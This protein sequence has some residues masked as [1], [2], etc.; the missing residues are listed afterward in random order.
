MN[1]TVC[2]RCTLSISLSRHR[3]TSITISQRD[4]WSSLHKVLTVV[5]GNYFAD[6][7][8][9]VLLLWIIT[10]TVNDLCHFAFLLSERTLNSQDVDGST[11]PVDFL[12]LRPLERCKMGECNMVDLNKTKL[13][14]CLHQ[15]NSQNLSKDPQEGY[16]T[17][18][19]Q[20][21]YAKC[22]RW[23]WICNY[24]FIDKMGQSC[25]FPARFIILHTGSLL[26]PL[27]HHIFP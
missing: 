27:T 9:P 20:H 16:C 8:S 19:L 15:M 18:K 3:L 1:V 17:P 13:G 5:C 12:W 14:R 2:V 22:C 6:N 25:D 24:K 21:K 4:T 26:L 23:C 11:R 10:H 7:L